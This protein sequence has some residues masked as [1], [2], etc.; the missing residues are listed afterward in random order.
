[1][2]TILAVL[3]FL[4]SMPAGLKAQEPAKACVRAA[5]ASRPDSTAPISAERHLTGPNEL[6]AVGPTD[7]SVAPVRLRFLVATNGRVARGT[8]DVTGT[9]DERWT[10]NA[11]RWLLHT[12]F[13]PKKRD[14]CAVPQWMTL[15]YHYSPAQ[16][17][18]R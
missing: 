6:R 16:A 5:R 10:I 9:S 18:S 2:K 12:R 11:R 7:A 13:V 17:Q 15:T 1:M 4:S 8:L 3:C 14:G